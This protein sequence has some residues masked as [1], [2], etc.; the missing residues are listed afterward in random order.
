MILSQ[1]KN[2]DYGLPLKDTELK[3]KENSITKDS[4]IL[5]FLSKIQE[6][7]INI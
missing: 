6:K 7:Y 2:I 3:I 5:E 1:S 4:I